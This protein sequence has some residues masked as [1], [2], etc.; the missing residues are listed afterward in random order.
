MN[1]TNSLQ[2][3]SCINVCIDDLSINM[4]SF[5]LKKVVV[6]IN[7]FSGCTKGFVFVRS[8]GVALQLGHV[9]YVG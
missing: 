4:P 5:S 1:F 9:L 6:L 8:F 7:S 2:K 3:I